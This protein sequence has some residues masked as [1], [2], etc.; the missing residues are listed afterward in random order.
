[1]RQS[2][3]WAAFD[4]DERDFIREI[5]QSYLERRATTNDEGALELVHEIDDFERN[6]P[7]IFKE[8][9]ADPKNPR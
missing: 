4:K 8:P 9:N 7:K 1:M 3:R 5:I 2:D 6:L